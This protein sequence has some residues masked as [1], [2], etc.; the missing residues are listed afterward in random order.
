MQ[1]RPR[2]DDRFD[3]VCFQEPVDLFRGYDYRWISADT[4][5]TVR[6]TRNPVIVSL[7][8]T[9]FDFKSRLD[10]I[11]NPLSRRENS[12]GKYRALSERGLLQSATVQ[13]ENPRDFVVCSE[14]EIT[15]SVQSC[16]KY[17]YGPVLSEFE[18]SSI[19]NIYLRISIIR[20]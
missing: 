13:R 10:Q 18:R 5:P 11:T 9:V 20:Y 17:V 4:V 3:A 15:K 2:F 7:L 14:N 6:V 16:R 19:V 8:R 12:R 1:R